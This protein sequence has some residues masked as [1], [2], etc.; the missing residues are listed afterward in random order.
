MDTFIIHAVPLILEIL[1]FSKS[2]AHHSSLFF[3]HPDTSRILPYRYTTMDQ[4][5]GGECRPHGHAGKSVS[6]AADRIR[7]E[8]ST[9]AAP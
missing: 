8:M 7:L 2:A 1:L 9:P 6:S 4:P 3:K 5:L